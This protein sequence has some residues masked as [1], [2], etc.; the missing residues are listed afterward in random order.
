MLL[1]VWTPIIKI[2]GVIV[3]K[4]L[5]W[6]SHVEYITKKAYKKLYSLRVLR[7]AGVCRQANILK[8]YLST[9]RPV[10]EYTVP[11]W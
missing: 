5:K 6:N 3:D 4:D 7:G 9:I 10:L 11:V 8:I 1:S 2:L